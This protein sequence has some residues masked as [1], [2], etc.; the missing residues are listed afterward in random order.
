MTKFYYLTVLLLAII[1]CTTTPKTSVTLHIEGS[2]TD[3]PT[4]LNTQDSVYSITLDS[5][6]TAVVN[7]PENFQPNYGMIRFGLMRFPVY[8]EPNKSFELSIKIEEHNV[9]P[10]FTGEGA[11]KNIYVNSDI[12]KN[13][14]P[15]L[16]VSEDV[17][18]K[19]LEEQKS[20]LIANLETQNFEQEFVKKEKK[21]IHYSLYSILPMYISYHPYYA[22]VDNY[23]PSEHFYDVLEVAVQEEP[24]LINM[25]EY[26]NALNGYIELAANKNMKQHDGL[27]SLKKQLNFIQNNFKSPAIIDFTVDHFISA[28][29]GRYGIDNLSEFLEIYETK[30]IDSQKK[31]SFNAL[32]NKWA[33]ISKGQPAIDFKYLD[34]NGKEVCL[35]DLSG[36]YIYIDCWATWC[37]PCRGEI[38]HLQKLEHRYKNKNIHF[39]SISC[40]QNKADWEKMVK[41]EKLG[42]IQLHYG[43][44]NTFMNFFMITGIPRFILLDQEGKII[45]ANA[46]RPSN[47]ETIKTFDNLRGI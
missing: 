31:S 44:D 40:D 11:N 39:V 17:F 38:P 21:R 20:K 27:I 12:F 45:Q 1:S 22:K 14:A 29:V 25:Q 47:P 28:Y 8:L 35:K 34:I 9:T 18:L 5:T 32:C 30:V 46:T 15:D 2:R 33:K 24:E 41:E 42:G 43:G 19:A 4:F 37:G 16:K 26:K 10:N 23:Q 36:K 3:Y 7:L 13:N 6:G